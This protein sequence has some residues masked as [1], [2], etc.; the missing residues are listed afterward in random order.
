M[1]KRTE[2]ELGGNGRSGWP[3]RAAGGMP[4]SSALGCRDVC[5][6]LAGNRAINSG[7]LGHNGG[8]LLPYREISYWRDNSR[9]R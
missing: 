4:R 1:R 5:G 9:I 8:R 3:A 6:T 7:T 2:G